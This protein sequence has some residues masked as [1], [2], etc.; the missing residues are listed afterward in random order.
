MNGSTQP[1]KN[2]TLNDRPKRLARK[3]EMSGTKKNTDPKKPS[4]GMTFCF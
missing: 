1:S 3:A 2:Q 4:T